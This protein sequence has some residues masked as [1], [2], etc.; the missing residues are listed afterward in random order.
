MLGRAGQP[1][2]RGL[3]ALRYRVRYDVLRRR[4]GVCDG[5]RSLLSVVGTLRVSQRSLCGV[6]GAVS[7]HLIG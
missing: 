3:P 2:R 7:G 4:L 5:F 6:G 1:Q